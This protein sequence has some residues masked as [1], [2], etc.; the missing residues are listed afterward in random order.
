ML[1]ALFEIA[2][3]G[4][5]GIAMSTPSHDFCKYERRLRKQKNVAIYRI[6][7]SITSG[8]SFVSY[9]GF[10]TKLA[11]GKTGASLF[12]PTNFRAAIRRYAAQDSSEV[13]RLRY[14]T[15]LVAEAAMVFVREDTFY[16]CRKTVRRCL[17]GAR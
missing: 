15:Y 13:Q 14:G 8:Q 17:F 10:L 7:R 5:V 6:T 12:T 16:C 11:Q 2:V 3:K 4:C 1:Y 9:D